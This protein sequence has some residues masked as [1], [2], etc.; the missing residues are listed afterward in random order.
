MCVRMVPV[1]IGVT[2]APRPWLDSE[3]YELVPVVTAMLAPVVAAPEWTAIVL[4]L[5]SASC[6]K[7]SAVPPRVTL[8]PVLSSLILLL[9]VLNRTFLRPVPLMTSLMLGPLLKVLLIWLCMA[10]LMPRLCGGAPTL[11]LFRVWT[12]NR[13]GL[14]DRKLMLAVLV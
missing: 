1:L 11:M 6:G 3:S 9:D 14:A 12:P 10:S 5:N 13:P 8:K 4:S 7:Q 2:V